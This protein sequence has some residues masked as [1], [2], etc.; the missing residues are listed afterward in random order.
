MKAK[1]HLMPTAIILS[2]FALSA[3]AASL[4]GTSVTGSLMFPGDPSNYFDPGYGFAPSGDLNAIDNST[5][6]PVS[7]SFVEFGYDDGVANALSA[8]FTG[9]QLTITDVVE[10]T[11][12]NFGFTMMFSDNSFAGYNL[13]PVNSLTLIDSYS[14]AGSNLTVSSAGRNVTA[15]QTFSDTFYF[16]AVPEPSNLGL[17]LSAFI[18]L[19]LV[20]TR[21]VRRRSA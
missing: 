16:S 12:T 18:G 1:L 6:V 3:N 15:G 17:C 11:G 19:A 5:T 4:V 10:G 14:L 13:I 2:A 21:N 20:G 9:T 8:D 7:N